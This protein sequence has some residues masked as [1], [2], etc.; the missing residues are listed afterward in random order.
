ML[1]N[2]KVF[3]YGKAYPVKPFNFQHQ[4]VKRSYCFQLTAE[5][6]GA[7]CVYSGTLVIN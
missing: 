7:G 6:K 1:R 5:S 4:S 3:A 2:G